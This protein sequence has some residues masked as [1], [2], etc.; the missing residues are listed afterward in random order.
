[1]VGESADERAP[2]VA[3]ETDDY[4]VEVMLLEA[5]TRRISIDPT[6]R[7]GWW[8]R[9]LGT[10]L[11]ATGTGALLFGLLTFR[12]YVAVLLPED[13]AH[14]LGFAPLFSVPFATVVFLVFVT[15]GWMAAAVMA[16][17]MLKRRR[18]WATVWFVLGL[19]SVCVIG[20][21]PFGPKWVML[22]ALASLPIGLVASTALPALRSPEWK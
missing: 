5:S 22:V 3:L 17:P 16:L 18:V 12:V 14:G 8:L 15:I 21:A 4:T 20:T 11:A 19:G 6:A 10:V 1:M 2:V 13:G 9:Y 7:S